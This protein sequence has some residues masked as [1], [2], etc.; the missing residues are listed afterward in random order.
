MVGSFVIINLSSIKYATV[1]LHQSSTSFMSI[2]YYPGKGNEDKRGQPIS[3]S[4]KRWLYLNGF[5]VVCTI[6]MEV[7][8]MVSAINPTITPTIDSVEMGSLQQVPVEEL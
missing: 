7:A 3:V 4:E 6:E 2:I 1:S 8:A 5:P